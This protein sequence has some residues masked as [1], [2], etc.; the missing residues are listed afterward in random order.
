MM[1]APIRQGIW[2][3]KDNAKPTQNPKQTGHDIRYLILSHFL[4]A[5]SHISLIGSKIYSFAMMFVT[6]QDTRMKSINSIQN[7]LLIIIYKPIIS[8]Q[9]RPKMY[10]KRIIVVC[11]YLLFALC[12]P[13]LLS[14]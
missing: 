2:N 11:I 7:K 10:A 6:E 13:Q 1:N 3:A 5:R 4:N 14:S 9:L 12:S 8:R